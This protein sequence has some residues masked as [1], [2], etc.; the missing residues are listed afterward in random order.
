MPLIPSNPHFFQAQWFH[1]LQHLKQFSEPFFL[2]LDAVLWVP[3]FPESIQS[4]AFPAHLASGEVRN[5]T[6]LHA[7]SVVD[8]NTAQVFDA[9]GFFLGWT[10]QKY[11]KYIWS[12]P[13][14][15]QEK[16]LPEL[17]K[18]QKQEMRVS[19]GQ[20]SFAGCQWQ[21]VF[22]VWFLKFKHLPCGLSTRC[23]SGK[24]NPQKMCNVI[25]TGED[26]WRLGPSNNPVCTFKSLCIMC[27]FDHLKNSLFK[28]NSS[29][30][31]HH[32]VFST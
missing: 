26:Y 2:S 23:I 19:Q 3:W 29:L 14:R 21:C 1:S 4:F 11:L 5:H 9:P 13:I 28:N 6:V 20:G 22:T 18:G 12:E 8:K 7:V 16:G 30:T 10:W 17:L 24:K 31:F 15:T 27:T 25:A 32:H